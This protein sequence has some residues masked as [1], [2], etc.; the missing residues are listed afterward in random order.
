VG[1]SLRKSGNFLYSVAAFPRPLAI[2]VKFCTAKRT[3]V[4]VGRVKFD[5]NRCNELPLLGEKPDFWRVSKYNT[6]SL[7][8]CGILPVTRNKSI[9]SKAMQYRQD[10]ATRTPITLVELITIS[11]VTIRSMW[12]N[13]AADFLAFWKIS[14]TKLRIL[15]RQLPTELRNL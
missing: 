6:S 4:P 8:L 9:T 14:A 3:H 1:D 13:S 7:L 5:V 2:E 10:I 15:W 12:H 11:I